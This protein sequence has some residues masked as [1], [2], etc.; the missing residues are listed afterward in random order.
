[1]N[2]KDDE[3]HKQTNEKKTKN[4]VERIDDK[5]NNAFLK[6]F[7]VVENSKDLIEALK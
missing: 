5:V 7:F 4:D 3:V 6:V 1:M 2:K